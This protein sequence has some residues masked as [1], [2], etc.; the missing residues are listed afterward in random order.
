MTK[1]IDANNLTLIK[2]I[3]LITKG[4]LTAIVFN[5]FNQKYMQVFKCFLN[6]KEN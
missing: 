6:L 2:K 4:K 3:N 5:K 1:F